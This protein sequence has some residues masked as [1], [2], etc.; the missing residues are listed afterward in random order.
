MRKQG[1]HTLSAWDFSKDD[2]SGFDALSPNGGASATRLGLRGMKERALA[3][4]GTL[5]IESGPAQG[6]KIRAY[7]P[8]ESKRE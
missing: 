2:G 8:T 5:E 4:G 1:W 6:T 3:L 7:F